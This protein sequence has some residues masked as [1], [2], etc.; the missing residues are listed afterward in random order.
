MH[1][2]INKQIDNKNLFLKLHL[3]EKDI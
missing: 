2:F 1:K 3:I